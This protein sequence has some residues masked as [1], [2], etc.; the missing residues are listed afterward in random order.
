[1]YDEFNRQSTIGRQ[2]SSRVE[3]E[4][5]ISTFSKKFNVVFSTNSSHPKR[6][7]FP[8]I[9]THGGIKRDKLNK[10]E[11]KLIDTIDLTNEKETVA[12]NKEAS[13]EKPPAKKSL[14]K[15]YCPCSYQSVRS[16]S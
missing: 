11:E 10:V 8:F 16:Q 3:L 15:F 6:G 13:F 12:K 2:F 9:C 14:H 7:E 1:M 5:C 4:D